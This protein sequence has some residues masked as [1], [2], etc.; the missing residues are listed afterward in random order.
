MLSLSML[1]CFVFVFGFGF[2][3]VFVFVFVFD[4]PFYWNDMNRR[5]HMIRVGLVISNCV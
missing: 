2:V 4:V 5:E 3:F 1:F